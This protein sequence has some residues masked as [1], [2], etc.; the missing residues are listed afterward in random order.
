MS[1]VEHLETH[2]GK[3]ERGWSSGSGADSLQVVRFPDQPDPGVVTYATLGLSEHLLAM[4]GGREVR[5]ELVFAAYERYSSDAIA[6][7]LLTFA[8]FI[9]SRHRAL[10]R[11]DVV[12]PADPIIPGV[13]MTAVY[14]SLP[15]VWRDGFAT[16][17]GATPPTVLVW[18]IPLRSEEAGRVKAGGWN[19]FEDRLEA[20][21]A[22]L[23]DL[24]R[25]AVR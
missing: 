20:S 3:I 23:F 7:F 10:L 18:L 16:H 1:I 5:Q 12:G 17:R 11:G 21:D 24:D 4:P 15:V 14:S 8:E 6:S 13:E 2:L 9:R 19:A 22:D 25:P